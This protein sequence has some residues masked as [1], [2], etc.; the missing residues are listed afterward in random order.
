MEEFHV[1]NKIKLILTGLVLSICLCACGQKTD[2]QMEKFKKDVEAFCSSIS[3][4]DQSINQI[5]P[6]SE[7]ATT[8]LLEYLSEVN[9]RFKAFADL[10]FPTDYDAL[11]HLADEASEYM[12][13]A[14]QYYNSAFSNNSYNEYNAEYAK[15]NYSRA[16][17]RIK[18]ILALLKG[19]NVDD[20]SVVISYESSEQAQ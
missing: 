18:I 20:P 5:D 1:R 12:S 14:V 16:I 9:M 19:E 15:E 3:T 6:N 8:Q 4:L 11:E 7:N 13:T 2:P 10:D 17:K